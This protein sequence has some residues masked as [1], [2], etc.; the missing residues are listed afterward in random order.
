MNPVEYLPGEDETAPG[1]LIEIVTDA[2]VD[3]FTEGI[4]KMVPALAEK[5][6]DPVGKSDAGV[7][8]LIGKGNGD[9]CQMIT[10][11]GR[12]RRRG[13][14]GSGRWGSVTGPGHRGTGLHATQREQPR[15]GEEL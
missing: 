8:F 5:C 4:I 13:L 7:G 6:G 11:G 12:W 1:I 14:G 10:D 15:E 2:T 3:L 9:D